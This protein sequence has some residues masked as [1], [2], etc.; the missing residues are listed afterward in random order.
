MKMKLD[1]RKTFLIGFGFFGVT[2]VWVLY[3]AFV[4]VLLAKFIASGTI[5]GLVMTF[6]NILAVTIQPIVGSVSDKTNTRIG[7]R[8]PYIIAG[9]P[10]AAVFFI[11]IPLAKIFWF[12]ILCIVLMNI[13]MALYRSPVVALMPDIIPSPLR[14]KANGIINFM[15][16]AGALLVFFIGGP[17]FDTDNRI[18][19]IG[20]AIILV[21]SVV[22][23]YLTIKEPK[24][25]PQEEGADISWKIVKVS[26]IAI[27]AGL[28]VF[29]ILNKTGIVDGFLTVFDSVYQGHILIALIIFAIIVFITML[30]W[31][32]SSSIFIF[33]AIFFWF[34]GYNGVET[35]FT[36]YGINTLGITAGRA[37]TILGIFSLTF[38]AFAIPSG[39][40]ATKIGRK[41]IIIFG[42]I[43]MIGL[44]ACLAF[45]TFIPIIIVIMFLGGICW[46]AINI[47]SI[48]MIWDISTEKMLGTYTGLYYFFSML[49]QTISPPI[50]GILK[51]K[52]GS[53][54]SMFYIVPFFFLLALI[55]ML[56]VKKGEAKEI[57][58]SEM[59]EQI[60]M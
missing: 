33:L 40:I 9:A 11:F 50:I 19:F 24:D 29:I 2:I 4:P 54:Q 5:I 1:Y 43:G 56:F 45:I 12:F 26:A 21:I 8:M 16:G 47:N 53:Y 13:F 58:K 17:L 20:I 41:K 25:I 23:L 34:F 35:F 60:D 3:N 18:P 7:R 39:I 10:V 37:A 36:L 44:M 52:T 30:R 15:G 57:T 55:C 14:S 48:P 38:L 31:V 49:A 42:L 32:E 59:L 22:V 27:M 46:A 28:I 6:D 51:D